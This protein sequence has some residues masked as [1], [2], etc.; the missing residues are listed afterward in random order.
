MIER[1]RFDIMNN[2]NLEALHELVKKVANKGVVGEY[3]DTFNEEAPSILHLL[4]YNELIEVCEAFNECKN[5]CAIKP[6]KKYNTIYSFPCCSYTKEDFLAIAGQAFSI[7]RQDD[8]D[9]TFEVIFENDKEGFHHW[10]PTFF[11]KEFWEFCNNIANRNENEENI[12]NEVKRTKKRKNQCKKIEILKKALKYNTINQLAMKYYNYLSR[13]KETR[14]ISPSEATE[15]FEYLKTISKKYSIYHLH[16]ETLYK[17]KAII[18]S[19]IDLKN[20][21]DIEYMILEPLFEGELVL[22][23]GDYSISIFLLTNFYKFLYE[24]II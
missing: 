24:H 18:L 23:D 6:H 22:I 10:Y 15:I 5:I 17:A 3:F 21:K 8:S 16:E 4:N 14:F 13:E 1:K 12:N 9:Y 2:L 7:C 20:F 11:V 19:S